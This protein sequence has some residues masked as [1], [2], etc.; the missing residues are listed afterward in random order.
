VARRTAAAA[1]TLALALA[2]AAPARAGDVLFGVLAHNADLGI[3]VKPVEGGADVQV[4]YRTL[5]IPWLHWGDFR[6][7]VIG[8][9]NTAGGVDFAA[10]GLSI[11]AHLGRDFY[12][13][14][15]IGGAVQDG[16]AHQYQVRP[17]RLSLGSRV[18][19]EPELTAGWHVTDRLSVEA[20]YDHLSHGQLAGAQNP[21]VDN[22]G[23]RLAWRLGR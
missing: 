14:P 21:G 18:L 23:V 19:F 12:I 6:A 13:A 3:T 10:A 1:A 16:D 17:D 2:A 7:H 4:G 22:V 8:E 11:R 5:Q 9:A 20:I 15:G